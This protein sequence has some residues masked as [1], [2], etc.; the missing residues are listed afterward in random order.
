[1]SD[2][3]DLGEQAA[4]MAV[5]LVVAALLI[6]VVTWQVMSSAKRDTSAVASLSAPMPAEQ[7]TSV[8]PTADVMPKTLGVLSLRSDGTTMTLAGSVPT[9]RKR[10]RLVSQANLVFG[11]SNVTDQL[12]VDPSAPLPNWKGK[13]LD[14]MARLRAFGAH[15]LVL[16]GDSIR[17]SGA[18]NSPQSQSAW[19]NFF[20]NFFLDTPVSVD[21]TGLVVDAT[22]IGS[23][24]DP[25]TLFNVNIEFASGSAEIPDGNEAG[26]RQIA[27]L[28]TEDELTLRVVGHTDNSGDAS[29]NQALSLARAQAVVDFLVAAGVPA[30]ALSAQGMGQ[31]QPLDDN[32]TEDGRA[33]NRRIEFAQ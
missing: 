28:L 30:T 24:I 23:T 21:A 4:F 19:V 16:N 8:A 22:M 9:E 13:T 27:Q 2:D 17:L 29:G 10:E 3:Q 25:N 32:A 6:G 26:L 12:V 5:G 14:L 20:A 33:R 31:D 11:D 1:M 15:E 18:V 7:P